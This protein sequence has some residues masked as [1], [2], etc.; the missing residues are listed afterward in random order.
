MRF[1]KG[2][3]DR[4]TAALKIKDAVVDRSSGV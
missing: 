1:R 4:D 3:A 2:F